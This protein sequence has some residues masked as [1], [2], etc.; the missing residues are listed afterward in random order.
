MSD[1]TREEIRAAVKEAV[2]EALRGAN[3]IDGPTHIAHHQA[4]EDML[5]AKRH[6]W[7]V[8]ITVIIGGLI[9]LLILGIKSWM[10]K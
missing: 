2:T 1:M 4:L 10:E 9:G 7:K 5:Q 6:A 3:L 8:S